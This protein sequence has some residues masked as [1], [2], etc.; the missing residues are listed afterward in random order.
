MDISY[1]IIAWS[2]YTYTMLIFEKILWSIKSTYSNKCFS[3]HFE[4]KIFKKGNWFVKFMKIFPFGK[5][6]LYGSKS[7]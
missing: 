5:Y 7:S 4:G 2:L 3:K 6:P 1:D